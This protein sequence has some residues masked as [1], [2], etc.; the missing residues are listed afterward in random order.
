[1]SDTMPYRDVESQFN[2][3]TLRNEVVKYGNRA[4]EFVRWP[5]GMHGWT[6]AFG[7]AFGEEEIIAYAEISE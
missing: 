2:L 1:M 5:D 3:R 4:V 6:Y 7:N